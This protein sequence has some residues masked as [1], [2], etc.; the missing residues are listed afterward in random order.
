MLNFYFYFFG[1]DIVNL[2]FGPI[3][4]FR[5][6]STDS[7]NKKEVFY[8][9]QEAVPHIGMLYVKLIICTLIG[10]TYIIWIYSSTK[11]TSYTFTLIRRGAH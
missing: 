7:A 10:D 8:I 5:S 4:N 6:P 3:S 9:L 1:V 2:W 11:G